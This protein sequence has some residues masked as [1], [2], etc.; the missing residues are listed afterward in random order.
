MSFIDFGWRQKKTKRQQRR[1]NDRSI[2]S[3]I[4][5]GVCLCNRNCKYS[6]FPGQT[7][8]F[9]WLI[10]IWASMK[11]AFFRTKFFRFAQQYFFWLES[12]IVLCADFKYAN[13]RSEIKVKQKRCV[14]VKRRRKKRYRQS[15]SNI[16]FLLWWNRIT[17]TLAYIPI[18]FSNSIAFNGDLFLLLVAFF[19]SPFYI[20]MEIFLCFF[21]FFHSVLLIYFYAAHS[22]HNNP[23]T[24]KQRSVNSW[25]F[26]KNANTK[27]EFH[28]PHKKKRTQQIVY[29]S[30]EKKKKNDVKEIKIYNINRQINQWDEKRARARRNSQFLKMQKINTKSESSVSKCNM[31][32]TWKKIRYLF[33]LVWNQF[34]SEWL[35]GVQNIQ[36]Q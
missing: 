17:V 13:Y 8:P 10:I 18:L 28:N 16:E 27:D 31:P 33:G 29:K 23:T 30:T 6:F 20:K 11:G 4:V 14:W 7:Q 19:L 35:A 26:Y 1:N 24:K 32:R 12:S 22:A 2:S 5:V 9:S 25:T 34:E 36:G 15:T 3:L 21:R